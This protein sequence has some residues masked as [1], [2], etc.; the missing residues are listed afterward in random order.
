LILNGKNNLSPGIVDSIRQ[1]IDL[2]DSLRRKRGLDD[3]FDQIMDIDE[4][5]RRDFISKKRHDSPA[6]EFYEEFGFHLP[7]SVD[8]GR[9]DDCYRKSIPDRTEGFLSAQLALSVSGRR[10]ADLCFIRTG[11]GKGWAGGRDGRDIDKSFEMWVEV[12]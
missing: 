4:A 8:V 5:G 9:P 12:E 1:I 7:G 11:A 6:D 2:S 3:T 10:A